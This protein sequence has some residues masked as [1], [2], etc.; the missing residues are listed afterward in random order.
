MTEGEAYGAQPYD[1][2]S[3]GYFYTGQY[4]KALAAVEKALRLTPN[5]S[6][7]QK[8]RNDMVRRIRREGV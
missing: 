6:R 1:L 3:L 8:N 4:R 2:L 7:L 5:D